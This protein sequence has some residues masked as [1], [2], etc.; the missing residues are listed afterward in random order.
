MVFHFIEIK[1]KEQI[2]NVTV[3]KFV[4]LNV[5]NNK[6][7]ANN[8][9]VLIRIHR[10][11]TLRERPL[12]LCVAMSDLLSTIVLKTMVLGDI[13]QRKTSVQFCLFCR[14]MLFTLIH[15]K[16]SI[17]PWNN[18]VTLSSGLLWRYLISQEKNKYIGLPLNPTEEELLQWSCVYTIP[19]T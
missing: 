4:E 15:T 19:L 3:F 10:T 8:L 13:Q 7:T 16:K 1:H 11:K 6:N 5:A 18:W 17:Y 14:T 2:I 9:P 12:K